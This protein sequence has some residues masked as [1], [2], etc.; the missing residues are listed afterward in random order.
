MY[1][2]TDIYNKIEI[3]YFFILFNL[4]IP[5]NFIRIKLYGIFELL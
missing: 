3:N 1:K 5:S 2:S 4:Y